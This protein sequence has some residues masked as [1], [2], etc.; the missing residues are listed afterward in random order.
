MNDEGFSW[1]VNSDF[2]LKEFINFAKEN[3]EK[4]RFTIFTWRNGKQRTPKQNA[5]LHVWLKMLSKALNEAGY[6]MKKVLKPHVEIPWDD[7][8][9]AAKEHL[10]RPIQEVLL[11]KESTTEAYKDE[12][13]K[14]YEVLNRH[15]SEKFGVSIP[16]PV[17][18]DSD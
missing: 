7:E 15:M 6:D 4:H 10:W 17:A 5:A 9:R 2:S 3:Y 1:T 13:A 16:W 8:G 14:V 12:Y 11:G 18:H